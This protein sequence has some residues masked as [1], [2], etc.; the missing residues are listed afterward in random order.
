M[1]H[2]RRT[3][4]YWPML[5]GQ[6]PRCAP[7]DFRAAAAFVRLIE[8]AI[9]RG[10]WTL[11]ESRNL[12]KLYDVWSARAN[13]TDPR[14]DAVGNGAGRLP[15]AQ[16]HWIATRRKQF[17]LQEYL[18]VARPLQVVNAADRRVRPSSATLKKRGYQ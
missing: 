9:D 7:G 2:M 10:G 12:R 11:A 3:A 14:F 17:A 13:G 1:R 8:A 6:A 16:E 18:R 4:R 5:G 15:R